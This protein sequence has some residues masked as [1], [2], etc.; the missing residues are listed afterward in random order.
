MKEV[1]FFNYEECTFTVS[2]PGLTII[3]GRPGTGK[4]TM[5]LKA[6]SEWLKNKKKCLLFAMEYCAQSASSLI[7]KLPEGTD[8]ADCLYIDDSAALTLNDIERICKERREADG[9]DVVVVDYIQL[10]DDAQ[11]SRIFDI[12][13]R[14]IRLAEIA[15]KYNVAIVAISQLSRGKKDPFE[16]MGLNESTQK[17]VDKVYL[18]QKESAEQSRQITIYEKD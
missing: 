13:E 4:T 16:L 7:G 18:L 14:A 17:L 3:A 8:P 6:V 12:N 2:N 11:P 10:I 9:L 15:K 5:A 1:G